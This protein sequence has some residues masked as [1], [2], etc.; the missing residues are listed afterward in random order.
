MTE[1]VCAIFMRDGAVLLAKRAAHKRTYAGCWDFVGG[2]VEPGETP[3]QALIREV[4]EETGVTPV[5]F[6][7]AAAI[8]DA[9]CGATYHL[10]LVDAWDGG[11]PVMLGDEH[12]ALRWFPAAEAAVL[13]GL[14]LDE[15]RG[16][17]TRVSTAA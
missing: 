6:R 8:D 9:A 5:R 2:H 16:L 4:R 14:A 15:Y 11:E 7:P 10:F 3:E 17:I 1:T 13:P 12:D